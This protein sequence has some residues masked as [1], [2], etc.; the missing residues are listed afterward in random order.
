MSRIIDLPFYL[1]F[2]MLGSFRFVRFNFSIDGHQLTIIETDGVETEPVTVDQLENFHWSALLGYR[3][4]NHR[5]FRREQ[6]L[7]IAVQ[8]GHCKQTCEQLL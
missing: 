6:V 7:M 8:K 3:K 5:T 1:T 2:L 4:Q